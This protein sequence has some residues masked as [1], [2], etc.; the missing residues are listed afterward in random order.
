M[1]RTRRIAT[2]LGAVFVL[3][4]SPLSAQFAWPCP[5]NVTPADMGYNGEIN[6]REK[7]F[8]VWSLNLLV[9]GP[10]PFQ[11]AYAGVYS[12]FPNTPVDISG[13]WLWVY[14]RVHT[15]CQ[16]V[17]W[18]NPA[19]G[20]ETGIVAVQEMTMSGQIVERGLACGGGRSG[21]PELTDLIGNAGYDPYS[22]ISGDPYSD[23][24]EGL[25]GGGGTAGG[26]GGEGSPVCGGS[27]A[28]VYETICIDV[29]VDGAGWVEAWCGVVA[30]CG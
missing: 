21:G 5:Q 20:V 8:L 12:T 15:K 28:L 19:T 1:R 13:Q 16:R 30:S 7:N 29:W 4:A 25:D 10:D 17:P 14:A 11:N 22:D 27:S 9:T 24:C 6:F 2:V 23:G 26:G 3:F 18:I